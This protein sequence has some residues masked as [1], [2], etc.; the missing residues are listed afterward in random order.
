METAER[1]AL[2]HL[3]DESLVGYLKETSVEQTYTLHTH[4]FPELFLVLR[5]MAIHHVNGEDQL[6]QRGSLVLIRPED[7]HCYRA[8]NGH[9]Y[10]MISCGFAE[11]Y[12]TAA[13]TYLALD[14]HAW[15][16]APLPH[17]VMLDDAALSHAERLLDGLAPLHGDAR[18]SYLRAVLPQLMH[19]FSRPA[20][21]TLQPLPAWLSDLVQKMCAPENF[22]AGLPRMLELANCSQEHLTR[23]FHRHVGF[24]PTQFINRKRSEYAAQLLCTTDLTVLDIC[25]ACGFGG[26]S[27]FYE[28][29]RRVY[30]CSPT[31]YRALYAHAE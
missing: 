1:L 12:L 18:A 4:T 23:A 31:R 10:R 13:C 19:I 27:S 24:T 11:S 6:V 28:S 30:D 3:G 15:L 20:A 29:F 8:F 17:A 25:Y 21:Q 22:T 26:P 7:T 5:G 2:D 14:I 9:E 16:T